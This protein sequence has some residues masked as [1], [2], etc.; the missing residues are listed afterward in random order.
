MKSAF[1]LTM[2]FIA[3]GLPVTTF[4]QEPPKPEPSS[5]AA[6]RI[7]VYGINGMGIVFYRD[8]ACVPGGLSSGTR[9][10]GGFG[11]A[12]G[13]LL[14]S[15]Q[16]ETIGMPPSQ[17]SKAPRNGV[18]AREFFKEYEVKADSPITVTMGFN[19]TMVV[20]PPGMVI[21]GPPGACPIIGGTFKPLAGTDYDIY[22]DVRNGDRQCLAIVAAIGASGE[23]VGVPVEQARRCP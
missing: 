10:S 23:G 15:N 6:A 7:R 4:A 14:G 1:L 3:T 2:L 8:S 13:S 18:M 5:P 17:R 11:Q 20:P 12:F 9:V 19:G 21:I 22:L 16:N